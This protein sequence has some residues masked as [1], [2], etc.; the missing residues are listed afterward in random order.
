MK[1]QAYI[2]VENQNWS[3]YKMEGCVP[4][5]SWKNHLEMILQNIWKAK[6]KKSFQKM[7]FTLI[8]GFQ[9]LDL[10]KTELKSHMTC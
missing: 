4:D 6:L 7:I 3:N 10:I 9:L 8:G 1:I 2:H 5:S